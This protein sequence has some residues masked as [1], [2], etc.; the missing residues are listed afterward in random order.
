MYEPKRIKHIFTDIIILLDD[1]KIEIVNNTII[2][3]DN[4][5][6]TTE[7]IAM[8]LLLGIEPAELVLD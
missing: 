5:T 4:D 1:G 8:A 2:Q 6:M 3:V 7:I